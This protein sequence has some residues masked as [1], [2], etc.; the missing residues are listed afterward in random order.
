M[1]WVTDAGPSLAMSLVGYFRPVMQGSPFSAWGKAA[2]NCTNQAE[3]RAGREGQL[4]STQEGMRAALSSSPA[5][6]SLCPS[7]LLASG[8][9]SPLLPAPS[10]VPGLFPHL[11][12]GADPY[13]PR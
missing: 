8:V 5:P 13:T 2:P 9:S 3:G 10:R 12:Y 6:A 1:H 7:P 11:C 4:G